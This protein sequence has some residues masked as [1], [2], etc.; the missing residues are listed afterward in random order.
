MTETKRRIAHSRPA[1]A[2]HEAGH[3]AAAWFLKIGLRSKGVSIVADDSTAG[4][5]NARLRLPKSPEVNN[6][7]R[8][9]L[10]AERRTIFLLA[11]MESQRKYDPRSVRHYHAHI[12][13]S[14]AVDLMS[15]FVH[16]DEELEV[17][18][19]LL[20]IRTRQLVALLWPRIQHLAGSLLERDSLTG[21]EAVAVLHQG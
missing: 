14:N 6:S 15:Y 3:A 11:G 8:M 7:D 18:L 1:T 17:Y 19:R 4:R 12:D 13:Y 10:R 16:D 5:C 9:R 20:V 2:Y 21:T